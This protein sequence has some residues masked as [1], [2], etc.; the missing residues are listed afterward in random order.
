MRINPRTYGIFTAL[1]EIAAEIFESQRAGW[2]H[3]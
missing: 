1:N 2:N 3:E